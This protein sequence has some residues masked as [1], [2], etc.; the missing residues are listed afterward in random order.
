MPFTVEGNFALKDMLIRSEFRLVDVE[1]RV[2]STVQR[3]RVS[4]L[5]SRDL[6]GFEAQEAVIADPPLVP[7]LFPPN[8]VP[9]G[10]V[11]PDEP[12]VPMV[13]APAVGMGIV[14]G[15]QVYTIRGSNSPNNIVLGTNI[16]ADGILTRV[17]GSTVAPFDFIDFDNGIRLIVTDSEDI[18]RNN[19]VG[20]DV[21]L[22]QVGSGGN[23]TGT[24]GIGV[25]RENAV[26]ES[27]GIDQFDISFHRPIRSGQRFGV[28]LNA[29]AIV[30]YWVTFE[31][32]QFVEFESGV[33]FVRERIVESIVERPAARGFTS[34]LMS[35]QT[36]P[37]SVNRVATTESL[38]ANLFAAGFRPVGNLTSEG[39]SLT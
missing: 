25:G 34:I 17:R 9:P 6:A 27:A 24:H 14:A 1:V 28:D 20:G 38:F 13:G 19:R 35:R 15:R 33:E 36:G 23:V 32:T 31:V 29:G 37:V 39:V 2:D 3:L 5:L 18:G 26:G 16:T 10:T 12:R 22:F 8:V 4:S 11:L 21:D 30:G 7:L